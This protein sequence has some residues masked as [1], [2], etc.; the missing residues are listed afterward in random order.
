MSRHCIITRALKVDA[1]RILSASGQSFTGSNLTSSTEAVV[2]SLKDLTTKGPLEVLKV[3]GTCRD[4]TF[5]TELQRLAKKLL[6][7]TISKTC[8][9][10]TKPLQ[11]RTAS[12]CLLA[13]ECTNVCDEF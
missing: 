8:C 12:L 6:E 7:V 3:L 9:S 11:V 1:L 2:E 4:P 13:Q 5:A 10:C